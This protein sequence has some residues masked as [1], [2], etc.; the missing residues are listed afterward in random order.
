MSGVFVL[1]GVPALLIARKF[2]HSAVD[3][4]DNYDTT[5]ILK[6][7]EERFKLKPL[8]SRDKAVR[9][10]KKAIEAAN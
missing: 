6:L 9:N 3:H 2:K 1:H 4:T 5:S 8:G 7:I 10:L